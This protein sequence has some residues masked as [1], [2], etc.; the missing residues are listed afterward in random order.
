MNHQCPKFPYPLS[1]PDRGTVHDDWTCDFCNVR[2]TEIAEEP[3]NHPL[4]V[5]LKREYFAAFARGEKTHEYRKLGARWNARTCPPGRPVCLSL[6]YGK[7]HRLAGVIKS[8][9]VEDEPLSL[10]GWREC[11]GASDGMAAD[12]EITLEKTPCL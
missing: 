3:I 11:Y 6:G 9:R 10:P 2:L 8:F 7:G 12:I 4:F 5:P 1:V